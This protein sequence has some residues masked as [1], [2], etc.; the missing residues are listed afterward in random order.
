MIRC[1]LIFCSEGA[2]RDARSNTLSAFN[3]IEELQSA[4]FPMFFP[5]LHVLAYVSREAE[6]PA[7][8]QI[9]LNVVMGNAVLNAFPLTVAFG[10]LFRHRLLSEINGLPIPTPG[11]LKF[12]LMY[13]GQ[14]LNS[15]DVIVTPLNNPQFHLQPA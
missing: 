1:R 3:I 4:A 14:E 6:D 5:R 2:V 13:N 8:I 7:Q 10:E 12:Q 11:S 9:T 15:W